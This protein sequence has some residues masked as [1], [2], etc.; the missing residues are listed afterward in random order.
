MLDYTAQE[1]T[2]PT[3]ATPVLSVSKVSPSESAGSGHATKENKP[4]TLIGTT[5]SSQE[6]S[7]EKTPS[8]HTYSAD[9]P[10]AVRQEVHEG[11]PTTP[12]SVVTSTS[13]LYT[14][15]LHVV[16]SSTSTSEASGDST[17]QLQKTLPVVTSIPIPITQPPRVATSSSIYT[18]NISE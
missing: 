4:V 13:K 15:P 9:T 3:P 8:K 16:T 12:L 7:S 5:S 6:A 11:D 18:P 1:P 17:I 2:V 14:Q 10:H